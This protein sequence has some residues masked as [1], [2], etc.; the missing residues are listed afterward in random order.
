MK[1]HSIDGKEKKNSSVGLIKKMYHST[2]E[3]V[4]SSIARTIEPREKLKANF[5][6]CSLLENILSWLNFKI[7]YSVTKLL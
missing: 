6:K 2:E 4:Q 3:F 7:S 1:S 5:M